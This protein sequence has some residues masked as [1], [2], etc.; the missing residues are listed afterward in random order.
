RLQGTLGGGPQ[1]A[2]VVAAQDDTTV[3]IVPSAALPAGPTIPGGAKGAVYTFKLNANEFLQWEPCMIPCAGSANYPLL[4]IS[5][6][7]V[8]SDKPIAFI[9]GSSYLCTSSATSP[10]GGGCDSDHESI[11]PVSALGFEYVAAPFAT[12][13]ADMQPESIPYRF[14]G[15]VDGTTL[16]FD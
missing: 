7:V 4:A 5:G 10:K 9:G 15:A 13:R 2:Q 16:A 12:R 1:W 6:R 11:P 3:T 14:V 8:L